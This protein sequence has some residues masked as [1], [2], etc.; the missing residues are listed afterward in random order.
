VANN[1][2]RG[3]S[4][5]KRSGSNQFIP[6]SCETGL[7]GRG[8]TKIASNWKGTR[9][10]KYFFEDK[11]IDG[12]GS[13]CYRILA[14]FSLLTP[15]GQ[16]YLRVESMPSEEVCLRPR[17]DRPLLTHVTID[18]T[19]ETTGEIT[20]KWIKPDGTALDTISVPGPYAYRLMRS[21]GI[22]STDFI[23]VPG[24]QFTSQTFAGLTDSMLIDPG[25]DTRNTGYMY[26][27]DFHTGPGMVL[28]GSS[29]PASSVFL[30]ASPS[31]ESSLLQW[32]YS[33]PWDN[34]NFEIWRSTQGGVFEL[35]GT[36]TEDAFKDQDGIING[37]E[38]CYK[39]VAYGDYGL[40]MTP[41]PLINL[42]QETCVIP[43]DNVAPC[44]PDVSVTNICDEASPE[45]PADAFSN[46]ISWQVTCP[47]DDIAYFII[48]YLDH[49][50]GEIVEIGRIDAP[51]HV[52]E[53]KPGDKIAGCYAVVA[54]DETGNQSMASS[55]VCVVNCPVYELPNA[56]TPNGDGQ[57][58]LFRPYLARFIETVNFK[59]FN[60]WGQ[61]VWST[62]DPQINWSGVNA[63]GKEVSD[64][65]YFYTC[66]AYE[67]LGQTP[68]LL[69]GYIELIRG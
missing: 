61:I 68:I 34:Y 13:Y 52:F 9:D 57:N 31:D 40:D 28:Y 60:R 35:V 15:S 8:Y 53:H 43:V 24:G 47:D 32:T 67:S 18:K 37:V 46:V 22:N 1:Y 33:T 27:V 50:G 55:P 26:K 11:D 21:T 42:S 45:V 14:E 3:F 58:D 63:N 51:G 69:N 30:T 65:V 38:Y 25:L 23:D 44:T 64:G 62:T 59:V 48:Y 6:D 49:Q 2:F 7:D 16:P 12:E 19:D 17:A 10:G 54:V 20:V 39:I 36:T 4:I 5:W 66:E 29:Q 41:T 56:F